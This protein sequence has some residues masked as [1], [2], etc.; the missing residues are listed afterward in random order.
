AR[1]HTRDPVFMDAFT[2]IALDVRDLEALYTEFAA[3]IKEGGEPGADVA[4]LKIWASETYCRL[5]EMILD[6][7][8]EHGAAPGKQVFG[9]T[10]IDA[11]NHYYNAR[12]APIYAG[13][14][15]IQRNIIAKLVLQL[16][17]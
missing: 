7:A 12:P 5:S 11:L 3:I 9:D 13:S 4:L 8:G 10:E 15:E 16:P 6:A 14:N 2:R 17:A 1:G